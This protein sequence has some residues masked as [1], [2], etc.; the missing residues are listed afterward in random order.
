MGGFLLDVYGTT[1]LCTSETDVVFRPELFLF[2]GTFRSPIAVAG[3]YGD[4]TSPD[5]RVCRKLGALALWVYCLKKADLGLQVSIFIVLWDVLGT[6]AFLVEE[7]LLASLYLFIR[8][9]L[10][11]VLVAVVAAEPLR[12]RAEGTFF[13]GLSTFLGAGCLQGLKLSC[14]RLLSFFSVVFESW[15]NLTLVLLM[16]IFSRRLRASIGISL[17]IYSFTE[18]A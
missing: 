3:L 5:F 10:V 16:P 7:T 9:T 8:L 6:G 14:S 2:V 18:G 4:I 11:L 15:M 12:S 1:F 17:D 13:V